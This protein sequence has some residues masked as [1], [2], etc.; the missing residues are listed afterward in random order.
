MGR[1]VPLLWSPRVRFP[2]RRRSSGAGFDD[3][4]ERKIKDKLGGL[5]RFEV[6]NAVGKD[7]CFEHQGVHPAAL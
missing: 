5:D 7:V 6:E 2:R 3:F 4:A 1:S